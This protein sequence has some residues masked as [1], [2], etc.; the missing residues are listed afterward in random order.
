MKYCNKFSLVFSIFLAVIVLFPLASYSQSCFDYKGITYRV[1][2]DADEA[3]TFG[4]V[5]VTTKNEG[6]YEGTITVPNAVKQSD[7]AFADAYKVVAIDDYAF[8][9]CPNLVEVT[10]P[11]S[12]ESIGISAFEECTNL[13]KVELPQGNLTQLGESVFAYSG[14]ESIKIPEGITA[15]P[16]LAFRECRALKQVVLPKTLKKIDHSVFV[17][18]QSLESIELPAGLIEI[19][20]YTFNA[21]GL[22]KIVLP[23]KVVSIPP[24]C[25]CACFDLE[26]VQL[27]PYTKSI[28]IMA[29]QFC[30][31]LSKINY[32][33]S[34]KMI[35]D[36][37]FDG[38]L[39]IPECYQSC[40]YCKCDDK[41]SKEKTIRESKALMWK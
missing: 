40:A 17:L 29:F 1:I 19:G 2:K 25:F 7:E 30:W 14:I 39:D 37:A 5:V 38:C 12:I 32:P 13:K 35:G 21:S 18:C 24:M 22:K 8:K 11:M 23:E 3:S 28:G 6:F 27:S 20:M 36:F 41:E 31:H 26:E 9:G 15:L 16:Y 34:L 33:E 10:L 4:T